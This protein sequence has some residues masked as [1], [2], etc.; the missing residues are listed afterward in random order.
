MGL[1]KK[2]S[3]VESSF[4]EEG[5]VGGQRQHFPRLVIEP[6]C[7]VS[8]MEVMRPERDFNVLH[9]IGPFFRLP[10]RLNQNYA[11]WAWQNTVEVAV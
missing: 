7:L 10:I 8:L 3:T 4:D 9:F 11:H 5:G 1:E 2:A 6:S